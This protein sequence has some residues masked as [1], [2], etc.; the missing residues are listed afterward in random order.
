MCEYVNGYYVP[1]ALE[2]LEYAEQN[3]CRMPGRRC[4]T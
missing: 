2:L 1:P 3:M 4:H